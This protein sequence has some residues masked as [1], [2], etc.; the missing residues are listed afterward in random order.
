MQKLRNLFLFILFFFQHHDTILPQVVTETVKVDTDDPAIWVNKS[1][2]SKSL[3]LGTDKG[4]GGGVYVFNLDGKIDYSR[5]VLNLKRVNNIDVAY[6]FLFGDSQ[7]DIA[8]ATER[9]NHAIRVFTL[10]SMKLIDG[11]GIKVFIDDSLQLPMGIALYQ[12]PSSHK[13]YAIVGR[14]DGPRDGYLHQYLLY[15]DA[16]QVKA[17]LVRKFG[18]YSGIKEIESIAVDNELGY[19]YY[20]D[21]RFGI[22]KYYANPDSSNIELAIF[23]RNEFLEDNEGISIYKQPNSEDGFIIVSNQSANTFNFYPR[24]GDQG[25]PAKHSLIKSLSFSTSNSDGSDISSENF[26]GFNNGLFVAMSDDRTF[27][28]YNWDRILKELKMK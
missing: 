1:D 25:N 5:S 16:G 10:P 2:L 21:E 19:V 20:S 11:D 12:E 26:P 9:D 28:F 13:I 4:L 24:M 17:T 6:G 18:K 14:K 8:V 15:T 22:R 23:G 3:V 27:H 7:I